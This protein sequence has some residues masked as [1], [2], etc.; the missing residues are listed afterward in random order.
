MTRRTLRHAVRLLALLALGTLPLGAQQTT[1]TP[2]R[3]TTADSLREALFNPPIT[4][5][6]AFFYSVAIPGL[7]QSSLRRFKS[8]AGF[9]LM[10][11]FALAMLHRSADDLRIAKSFQRD[12]VPAT[13]VT[14]PNTGAV[15]LANGV[16]VVATW[17]PSGYTAD[18]IQAR[19]LQ[20]EDWM[21]VVIF[22][23]LI[24]GTDAFVAAQLWD[25]PARVALR[26][27]PLPRGTGVGV[28]VGYR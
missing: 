5:K 20:V 14:D 28:S 9:F 16:P 3:Q 18:L 10:E 24:A 27:V 21:A 15:Q 17:Q 1:A 19:K 8:G 13:Y 2:A 12:S 26:A 23:H 11:A 6:R 22:N 7:G 25:I 4:P